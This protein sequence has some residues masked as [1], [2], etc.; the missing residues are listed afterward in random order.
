MCKKRLFVHCLVRG[1][2]R[3]PADLPDRDE[4]LV[5]DGIRNGDWQGPVHIPAAFVREG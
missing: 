4:I 2:S 3:L 5:T 1:P